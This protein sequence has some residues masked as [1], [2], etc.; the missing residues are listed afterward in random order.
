MPEIEQGLSEAA[1]APV[2]VSF[3]PHLMPMSRSVLMLSFNKLM[4]MQCGTMY[5]LAAECIGVLRGIPS[6]S[7]LAY[8][9]STHC[10]FKH[11][12]ILCQQSLAWCTF[13]SSYQLSSRCVYFKV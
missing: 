1:K 4:Y 6:S 2:R 7:I 13:F 5:V 10:K 12:C 8:T 11:V 3:T 9:L